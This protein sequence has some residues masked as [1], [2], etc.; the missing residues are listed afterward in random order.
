MVSEKNH[1]LLVGDL[2][3]VLAESGELFLVEGDSAG[4]NA[5]QG[6]DRKTQAILPLRGKIL[7]DSP[8]F[9]ADAQRTSTL[10]ITDHI[11][12]L[13]DLVL[14]FFD[15][16]HPEPG[17]MSDTLA[18]LVR[19]NEIDFDT[20]V[21][22][23]YY[24]HGG[25]LPYVLRNLAKGGTGVGVELSERDRWIVGQVAPEL[26]KRGIMFAG[27]DVIGDYLTEVNVTSPTCIRELDAQFGLNIAGDL[28]DAL[29]ASRN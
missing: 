9:D 4:G 19:A 25:I 12:D 26:V 5:K 29:E 2:L 28:F 8:G 10:K 16:R 11:I 22:V 7:I 18:H 13:S 21:E 24:R 6:R 17:A 27:L 20:A 3:L 23:E 14:V 15:A 1:I